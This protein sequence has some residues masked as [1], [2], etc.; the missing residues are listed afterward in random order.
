MESSS[1]DSNSLIYGD[2]L[3]IKI[4]ISGIW[5]SKVLIISTTLLA[6]ILTV[7]LTLLMSNIYQSSV[8]LEPTEDESNQTSI[9]FASMISSFS[10][11]GERSVSKTKQA[12]EILDSKDFFESL[13]VNED[14]I[15]GLMAFESYKKS[16]DI[17]IYNNKIYG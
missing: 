7:M 2:E 12:L 14:F 6:T 8:V 11:G 5:S 3:D 9:P 1:K 13:Y 17:Y 10:Q 16:S 15:L 4:L